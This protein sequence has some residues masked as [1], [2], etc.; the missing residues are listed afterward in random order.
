[1]LTHQLIE[2]H[3]DDCCY[4]TNPDCWNCKPSFIITNDGEVCGIA[5][6]LSEY[7]SAASSTDMVQD[8]HVIYNVDIDDV[9]TE[10]WSLMRVIELAYGTDVQALLSDWV[11]QIIDLQEKSAVCFISVDSRTINVYACD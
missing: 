2:E 8:H 5:D 9:D 11:S 3:N 4:R 6:D 10:E 7:M 1:M